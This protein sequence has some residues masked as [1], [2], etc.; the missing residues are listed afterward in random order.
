MPVW[1]ITAINIFTTIMM[2]FG[3]FGLVIPIFPGNVIM[4]ITALVYGLIFGFGRTGGIIFGFI[5]LLMVVAV[6]AD[7]LMMGM[8]AKQNGA[9]W[10]S[11]FLALASGVI[12]TFIFPPVGGIIAAPLVLYLVEFQRLK[13]STEATNVVKGMLIGWGQAFVIR[14]GLGVIMLGLWVVWAFLV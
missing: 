4:W 11:I 5:S 9:A 8:K 10:L 14:F 3:L 6:F 12:F 7:N 2:F 1:M 13:D